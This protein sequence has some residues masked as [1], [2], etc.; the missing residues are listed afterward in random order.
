MSE[1][2]TLKM[3]EVRTVNVTKTFVVTQEDIDNDDDLQELF[4]NDIYAELAFYIDENFECEE[5][6]ELD[7]GKTGVYELYDSSG[8]VLYSNDTWDTSIVYN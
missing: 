3:K 6:E 5:E 2:V 8:S 1:V 4:D 7:S